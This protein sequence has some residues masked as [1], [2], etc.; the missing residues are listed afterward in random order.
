MSNPVESY[1]LSPSSEYDAGPSKPIEAAVLKKTTENFAGFIGIKWVAMIY[2]A[3]IQ[4]VSCLVL[5]KII[6]KMI[7]PIKTK[8]NEKS[9]SNEPANMYSND[10]SNKYD[11]PLHLTIFYSFINL[12]LILISIYI[13][14]NITQ[15]IPFP[16]EGVAGY[17]HSRLREINGVFIANF[18]LL[19][20]QTSFID[21]LKIMFNKI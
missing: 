13:M 3:I 1:L 6:S 21:R 18:V 16:F 15:R 7:P 10:V 20:Y 14:R 2:V 17:Q 8:D 12:S 11:E 9:T 19:Y 4:I 5:S